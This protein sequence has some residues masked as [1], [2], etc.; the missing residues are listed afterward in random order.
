MRKFLRFTKRAEAKYVYYLNF[1]IALHVT[2]TISFKEF[3]W[4]IVSPQILV[5]LRNKSVPEGYSANFSC[6][7][8]GVPKPIF[9]WKF[10]DRDLPSAVNQVS[11]DEGSFL[12]L[13]YTT[14][15]MEGIYKCTAK[16]KA[17]AT[18]S[19]AYL[20]VFGRQKKRV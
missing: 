16:N 6:K 11:L 2:E 3:V 19:L 4:S 13:P 8:T 7:A 10:N 17:N 9:S 20:H 1:F 18:T 5:P 14:K 15:Q 12:E